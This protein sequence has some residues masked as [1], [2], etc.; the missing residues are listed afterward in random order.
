MAHPC[1]QENS[2]LAGMEAGRNYSEQCVITQLFSSYPRT[3]APKSRSL[4]HCPKTS[5]VSE[6]TIHYAA[7]LEEVPSHVIS[8]L[9]KI[10]PKSFLP[11]LPS[12]Q[13]NAM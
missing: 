4:L 11:L 13:S 3:F 6:S 8:A 7:D 2:I 5:V 1:A 9:V 12:P 10:P